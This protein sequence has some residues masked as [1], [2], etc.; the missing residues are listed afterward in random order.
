M[1]NAVDLNKNPAYYEISIT[2]F[3]KIYR[4]EEA[5]KPITINVGSFK[6]QSTTGGLLGTDYT[7]KAYAPQRIVL[8][9]GSYVRC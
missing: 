5:N 1:V 4:K 3:I 9:N 8:V 7:T 6:L 2:Q